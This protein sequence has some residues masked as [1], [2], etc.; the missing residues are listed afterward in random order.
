MA[1][2][3]YTP[4]V[5]LPDAVKN[6]VELAETRVASLEG[7]Q[8]RLSGANGE[9]KI[10]LV[11]LQ[12]QLN[13]I[14]VQLKE[15]NALQSS[16]ESSI[17]IKQVEEQEQLQKG[18]VLAA[19][20]KELKEQ[21]EVLQAEKDSVYIAIAAA[22]ASLEEIKKDLEETIVKSSEKKEVIHN[23]VEHIKSV[24]SSL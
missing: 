1:L 3:T 18:S 23:L 17:A 8:A 15:K 9:L 10:E 5:D 6:A 2:R 21:V 7:E 16:L 24:S 11:T 4:S 14:D 19:A 20:I 13:D 12:H 22:K